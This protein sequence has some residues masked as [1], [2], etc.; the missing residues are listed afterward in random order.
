[1]GETR[2][3]AAGTATAR[4]TFSIAALALV[5][6]IVPA[7]GPVAAVAAA[8]TSF[9]CSL[10][11][12]TD[13][14][15]GAGAS[16]S[17][18]GWAGNAA[19]V[20]TCLGGNFY[21]QDGINQAFGFGIYTGGRTSWVDADGYLPAQVTTFPHDGARVVITEF[22]DQVTLGG[23][24]YVAVYGRVA[25][26]NPTD[27]TL[28]ADPE[29]SAG[30]IPLATAPATVRAHG[31]GVH[32]YVLAVDRFG[33]S[34]PWP[35]S[36][37]L[38]AAGSFNRH[39]AHM[40]AFWNGQLAHIADV[41]VPDPQLNNAYRSGFISTQIARSGDDLNTGVN[42]Y[43]SE[44]SHD[45]IGILAN[46]FTQGDFE[47]AHAL[48]LESRHVVGSQ[49]QYEDGV[50]TYD[51]PWAIYLMK[52]GDLAFVKANFATPG[53]DG[54]AEPSIEATAHQIAADRTGP[55]GI[56]GTTDD[57]D[58]DGYWTVD[59]FEALMG[60]AAYR[61]L[62]QAV[63]DATEEQWASSEY[64]GLLAATNHVLSATVQQYHLTYIPCSIVQP[65]T[66]NRCANP[67]DAN[68][69]APLL[70]GRWAWDAPLFGAPVSGPGLQLIDG[71]YAYGFGRL[72]GKLPPD[73]FG[74]YPTDYYSTAYNAGYGSWGLAGTKYRD[75][76]ILG[77]EFMIANTQSGPYSWW[78]SASAPPA[79]SAWV[80]RHPAAGQGSSPHAWGM[81]NANLVLLD[82]LVAQRS[83]GDLI[84][85]RGV[86]DSW[87]A[88]G[89]TMSVGNFPTTNGH[90]LAAVITSSGRAATLRISGT[91]PTGSVLFQLPAFL[92]NVAS[93]SAGHID[94]Q[95]G[96]VA[97]P[98]G[99]RSVTVQLRHTPH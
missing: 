4:A 22:A 70:F 51:W 3:R 12:S 29:P 55:D 20:T 87:V 43:A 59:D 41:T 86:P 72:T 85:G 28:T 77:Y 30:L 63:G 18:I 61:Y 90:R 84:V 23:D 78:E 37:S 17:A 99:V 39:F 94:E 82:S 95:T 64:A 40:R 92:D 53:P 69:A 26:S 42:G 16:A 10:N 11:L 81:A 80:G 73:T 8:P 83:D 7:S 36:Q 48:L 97:L 71:T 89:R 88:S 46:L 34:Y 79:T 9:A 21:V 27:H 93:T 74:G 1:V 25:V 60:L 35:S 19:G 98:A 44:F 66:A 6:G 33:H 91:S 38:V 47:D 31:S 50:W 68:W 62:A 45:V 65:N 56:M 96:T 67:E 58:S 32:D 57:I 14:V 24:A 5:A 76:G 52:T 2:R 15:A 54:T 13:A 49:G 75:Q